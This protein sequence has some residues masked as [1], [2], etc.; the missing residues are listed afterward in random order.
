M[1]SPS[2]RLRSTFPLLINGTNIE[3]SMNRGLSPSDNTGL[4]AMNGTDSH[5][6]P[7]LVEQM[8][9]RSQVKCC[10]QLRIVIIIF[11]L[12]VFRWN[13]MEAVLVCRGAK[14]WIN[15]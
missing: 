13:P 15:Y 10:I 9:Y 5:H 3:N 2:I 8:T 12:L 1:C 11:T 7:I 4:P 14:Y 6:Y